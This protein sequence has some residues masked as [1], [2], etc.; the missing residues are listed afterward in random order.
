MTAVTVTISGND[1]D[2]IHV[3]DEQLPTLLKS[4]EPFVCCLP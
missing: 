4:K 1:I 3:C 2:V